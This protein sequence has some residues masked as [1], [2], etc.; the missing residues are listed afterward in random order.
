MNLENKRIL[1]SGAT[2][3]IGKQTALEVAKMNAEIIIHGR[4]EDRIFETI[5][6]IKEK[7]GNEKIHGILA[8]FASL[9][10]VN[11][12]ADEIIKNFDSIDVLFNNAAEIINERTMTEDGFETQFQVNYLS[13]FLLTEKLLPLL[14]ASEGSRVLNVS[15]M[16]H[17]SDL[18][19]D[20]LQGEKSYNGNK[21]Y[22]V[23]K[24]LNI[25]HAYKLS[26]ELS[27]T[28]TVVHCLHPGVIST[29]LLNT[30][31]KGGA[32]VAEGA[33][34]LIY[35]AS[36]DVARMSSGYYLENR[37]PMQSNPVSYDK[38]IQNKLWSLSRAYVKD[39]LK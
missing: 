5:K 32:P 18:D 37:R 28:K 17:A 2:D 13:H 33:A 10:A 16:I 26:D 23:T 7:T 15:S 4:D 1:I 29:K 35:A 36:S 3:G 39:F 31:F 25:L 11:S 24:L 14:N 8:D 12:L 27:E 9:S 34:N 6:M 21:I 19:F 38:N 22:A 20:N 30:A